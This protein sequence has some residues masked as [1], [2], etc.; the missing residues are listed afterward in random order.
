[1]GNMPRLISL[2]VL[3][4]LIIAL[5][6]TF[7]KVVAPFLLPLFLAGMTAVVCQ[8]L[9]RYFL[10]RTNNRMHLAAGLTTGTLLGAVMGPLVVGTVLASLQLY[11]VAADADRMRATAKIVVERAT[12]F[13]DRWLPAP[14]VPAPPADVPAA[15]GDVEAP[16]EMPIAGESINPDQVARDFSTWLK[17]SL[18]EMGNKS[19]GRA[20]GTTFGLLAGATGMALT[21]AV[22]LL[23]YSIGLYY[24]LADGTQLLAA[25]EA[26]I[27]VSVDYQRQ[28]T[29][30]FSQVVRAVVM[31]TF[32][33]A[34]GQGLA[35]ALAIWALGFHHIFAL[36]IL[37]TL[38]ALIPVAGTWV[39]WLPCAIWLF[40]NHHPAQGTFLCLY[41]L[42]FVGFL[43]NVIRTYVLN[44]DTK[45]HPLLAFISVL[46]GIQ[47]MGLWGVFIGP[48]VACCLYALMKIFN[49]ELWELSRERKPI[50]LESPA[51]LP[52]P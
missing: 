13:K 25:S 11:A 9:F 52:A 43:D 18:V 12:E 31:A 21:F 30:E 4:A 45:L 32:L 36:F 1:M 33:A 24:F 14:D 8:P 38:G 35:T 42:I 37:A 27:P 50:A 46:G 23:M 41:G 47:A 28:L 6:V 5:G 22:G 49:Q 20:A 2:S 51:A 15:P 39:V 48:I 40:T 26:L 34:L 29:V 3:L 19:L 10:R 16:P 17:T 44:S 7:F